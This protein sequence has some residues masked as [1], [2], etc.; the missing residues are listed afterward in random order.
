M[1]AE[2]YRFCERDPQ[3]AGTS[4]AARPGDSLPQDPN[5][6]LWL[7]RSLGTTPAELREQ[8]R[9]VTRRA[10]TVMERLF[11]GRADGSAP[12]LGMGIAA[13]ARASLRLVA[14]PSPPIG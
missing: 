2:A 10:R 12:W 14:G 3:P 9:R 8:Y 1:L 13:L 7:A 6:L 4:C 11:Y 5:E